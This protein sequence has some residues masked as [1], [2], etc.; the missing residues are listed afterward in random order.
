MSDRDEFSSLTA[1]KI[2]TLLAVLLIRA[3]AVVSVDQL[4]TEIWGADP[5]R[6]ATAGLH[7]YVSQLRKFLVR[8]WRPASP[9]VTKAPGY[10]LRLDA[11]DE[12]D[13][14][15]FTRLFRQGR[16]AARAERHE[17]AVEALEEALGMCRGL[18]LTEPPHGP[19]VEGFN[20]WLEE[21]RLE[22]QEL[23][24]DSKLTIG[25]HRELVSLLYALTMEHPLREAFY[26][27]LMLALYRSQRQ[28]EA[29][30]V[31]QS[32]RA[33]LNDELGLEP[34]RALRELQRAIL[35]DDVEVERI[36]ARAA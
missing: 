7:V 15:V 27:Q 19:I 35:L 5:P 24:V 12:L 13:V 29:L 18:A 22:C 33:T 20:A 36:P 16:E 8:P 25:Q 2:E 11:G 17:E 9:V 3:D 23:L 31:Y 30:K 32:A 4:L 34:C 28:A 10:L 6:R 26:R 21:A 1:P 14:H